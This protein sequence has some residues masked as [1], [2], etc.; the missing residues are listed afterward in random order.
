M[1]A[2]AGLEYLRHVDL[3]D[4][5][6][7]R[8]QLLAQILGMAGQGHPVPGKP[9]CPRQPVCATESFSN[10]KPTSR[11]SGCS[12]R[13]GWLKRVVGIWNFPA[14]PGKVFIQLDQG[15]DKSGYGARHDRMVLHHTIPSK[16]ERI[17]VVDYV[18][19]PLEFGQCLMKTPPKNG[20]TYILAG[21]RK[22]IE[23]LLVR[24]SSFRNMTIDVFADDLQGIFDP[25]VDVVDR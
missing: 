18:P 13:P 6:T 24:R 1:N 9:S 25:I 21:C 3:G 5:E 16:F 19:E 22:L 8:L 7:A 2:S 10:H 23:N 4:F 15:G 12:T 14:L 11:K 20:L 17:S